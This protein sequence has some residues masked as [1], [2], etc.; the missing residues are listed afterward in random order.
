MA[1]SN[2]N[3]ISAYLSYFFLTEKEGKQLTIANAY[4]SPVA[5]KIY[6]IFTFTKEKGTICMTLALNR[7]FFV[8]PTVTSSYFTGV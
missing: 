6:T 2:T 4:L 1:I 5:V 3:F 8:L 7:F